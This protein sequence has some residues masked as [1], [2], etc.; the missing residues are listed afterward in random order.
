MVHFYESSIITTRDGLHCQVYGNE[1]PFDSILV[2][3]KYIPTDK[4]ENESLQ[5]RFISGRKMNRLNL[6]ADK[7]KLKD[8]ITQFKINYPHYIFSSKAHND[9]QGQE[10][11]FF[12]VP[13]DNIE[14][15][16]FPRKGLSEL[17]SMPE[18]ALDPHIKTV[19]HFVHF[20][21]KSGLRVKDLGI[22][23]S[24]LTGHYSPEI[25]DI[26]IVVYGKEQFWRLMKFLE[27][28]DHPLLRWK[29]DR[30]W[31]D[32]F[33]K[34]NRFAIFDEKSFLYVMNRKKSEGFFNNTLFVIFA[35]EKEEETW[36]KWGEETYTA[37]GPATVEGTVINNFDS[38]VRPG[39]Y[40]IGEARIIDE[41]KNYGNLELK[42]IVFY[43]RDYCMIA[44]PGEKVRACGVLEEVKPKNGPFY[45]R[46]VVGYFDA[47]L[48][49]RREKEYIK[50]IKY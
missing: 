27:T 9:L 31:L 19:Y 45:H 7:N 17:M 36:F 47:Y 43:S 29:T 21:L 32:F 23:Y 49:D 28:A 15:I 18:E 44:F 25:S 48:S 40:E 22:T 50:V 34:R 35:A 10:R 42:K 39:C 4:I 38:V 16:Y 6:W 3:P 8:Y 1:H 26:N 14:K 41:D 46:L 2:K 33:N 24:T 20:L 5:Y 37:L 13:L 30:E 12:S 11:L